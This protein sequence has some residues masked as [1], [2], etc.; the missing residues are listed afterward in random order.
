[1]DGPAGVKAAGCRAKKQPAGAMDGP[2]GVKKVAGTG[3]E[4]TQFH[5][6]EQGVE[7]DCD[8]E[9]DA[10][11][12]DRIEW[13]IRAVML[14]A[15][16]AIPEAAGRRGGLQR[17]TADPGGEKSEGLLASCL[18]ASMAMKWPL[19]NRDRHCSSRSQR[20]RDSRN[21]SRTANSRPSIARALQTASTRGQ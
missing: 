21:R 11:S 7:S 18:I 13:L 4:Q 1:M 14:V 8:A 9:C 20:E 2:A 17:S 19:T 3:T 15:G 10:I 16:M 12:A 6:G 5:S